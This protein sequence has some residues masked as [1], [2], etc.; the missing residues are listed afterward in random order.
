MGN[1]LITKLKGVIPFNKEVDYLDKVLVE[2]TGLSKINV[3]LKANSPVVSAK[4]VSG[5]VQ[6]GVS[7]GVYSN[8][9][10]NVVVNTAD[11][12][13]YSGNIFSNSEG[14]FFTIDFNSILI[15]QNDSNLKQGAAF[16]S[17]DLC[18]MKNLQEISALT[19]NG[20]LDDLKKLKA[21]GLNNTSK[22]SG[23]INVF[24]NSKSLIRLSTPLIKD[25]YGDIGILG[26]CPNITNIFLNYTSVGGS[27]EGFIANQKK[28]NRSNATIEIVNGG[29]SVTYQ[30]AIISKNVRI[31]FDG[32]GNESVELYT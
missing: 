24:E 8:G 26:T 20:S 32:T 2:A 30:G 21:I 16:R 1:C 18:R 7:D 9:I 12:V 25:I 31:T 19:V 22:I 17:K 27:I 6:I 10:P 29:N 28:I 3:H 14:G 15:M 11:N 13:T 5:N 4:V 23:D